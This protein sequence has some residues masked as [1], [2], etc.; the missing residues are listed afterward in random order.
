ML[1]LLSMGFEQYE[2]NISALRNT[3]TIAEAVEQLGLV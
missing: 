3:S 2:V 1:Y